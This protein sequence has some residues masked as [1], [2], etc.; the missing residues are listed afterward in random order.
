[1]I[2]DNNLL[3]SDSQ[4]I[5]ATAA[6]TNLIDLGPIAT[7]AVSGGDTGTRQIGDGFPIFIFVFVEVAFTDSGSDSTLTVSVETDD[8][9]S[10]SSAATVMTLDVLAALTAAGSKFFYR[11]P[12]STAAIPYERYI[13]L[14][15]TTTNGNLTTGTISAGLCTGV[16][17]YRSYTNAVSTGY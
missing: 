13:R 10:F 6:S 7:A 9:T 14:K 8:N 12:I 2:L 3:F 4:A 1:M 17:R 5:T 16:D 15:Y 11:L